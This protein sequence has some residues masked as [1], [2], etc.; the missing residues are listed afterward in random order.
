MNYLV[1]THPNIPSI[2]PNWTWLILAFFYIVRYSLLISNMYIYIHKQNW[3]L[4][5]YFS[6]YYIQMSIQSFK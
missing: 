3:P 5:K 1:L 6:L 2:N 4:I